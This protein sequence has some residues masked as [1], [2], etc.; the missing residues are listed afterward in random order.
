MLRRVP[1]PLLCALLGLALG[2]LPILFHGPIPEKYNIHYIRGAVA[3]WGWYVARA[4]VG[5]L[6]GITAVPPQWYLRG[7]LCGLFM[8]VPLGFVSIATPECGPPCMFWNCF[9]AALVGAAVG[10][11]AYLITGRNHLF[12][13]PPA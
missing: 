10:G 1:Y 13:R 2:W 6:V 12:D 3:V 8:M 4:A 7:P 11:L 5:T 9:T